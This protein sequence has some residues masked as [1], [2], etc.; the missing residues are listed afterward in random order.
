[1]Q[2]LAEAEA[3]QYAVTMMCLGKNSQVHVLNELVTKNCNIWEP[4]YILVSSKH[5][6]MSP[7][8]EKY[9]LSLH[10]KKQLPSW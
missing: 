10:T 3:P 9:L 1:M 6:I 2:H 5:T 7:G 4:M 8:K